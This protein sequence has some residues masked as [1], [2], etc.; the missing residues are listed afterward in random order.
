MTR[1]L[2]AAGLLGLAVTVAGCKTVETSAPAPVAETRLNV[3]GAGFVVP[4][5]IDDVLA[6]LKGA[7]PDAARL[8]G[9]RAEADAVQPAGDEVQWRFLRRR[10]HARAQL[11]RL[12]ESLADLRQSG[13]LARSVDIRAGRRDILRELAVAEAESG[14]FGQA[15]AAIRQALDAME[16]SVGNHETAARVYA[17]MGDVRRARYHGETALALAARPDYSDPAQEWREPTVRFLILQ[18]EGKWAEAESHIRR[19]MDAWSKSRQKDRTPNWLERRQLELSANLLRQGRWQESEL[20]AREVLTRLLASS[21]RANLDTVSAVLALAEAVAAQNRSADALRLIDA[22]NAI[23][24]EVAVPEGARP[25]RVASHLAGRILLARGDAPSALAL[26]EK[27]RQGLPDGDFLANTLFRQSPDALLALAAAGRAAEALPL[28]D[29]LARQRALAYG[30]NGRETV[31]ARGVAAYARFRAGM[32]GE[33]LPA[34]RNFAAAVED[35]ARARGMDPARIRMVIEG[36]VG[37][38]AEAY[39][40][41]GDAGLA[42]EAFA[43][44]E[45]GRDGPVRQAMAAA[46]RRSVAGDGATA[47]MVRR[48][49]DLEQRSETLRSH[50]ARLSA[51]AQTEDVRKLSAALREE[52]ETLEE[53][54]TRLSAT[55]AE[56][57]PAVE[58]SA[59]TVVRDVAAALRPDE[60][61]VAV[62]VAADR[63]YVWALN[64]QGAPHFASVP[65]GRKHVAELVAAIRRSTELR[66]PSLA[67]VPPFDFNAAGALFDAVLRPVAGGWQGARSLVVVPDAA[68]GFL[69][70]SMLP[71]ERTALP[72]ERGPMFAAYRTVPWLARTHAVATVPSAAALVGIRRQ[73]AAQPGRKPFIGFGDPVFAPAAAGGPQVAAVASRGVVHRRNARMTGR[74]SLD[75]GKVM[76]ARLSMLVPLP[77]TADEVRDIAQALGGDAARDVHLG[78]QASERTVKQTA[79]ADRSVVMFATHG[80]VAGDLDGLNQPALALSNPEVV[81]GGGDGLLT[82]EEVLALKLDADWVVLSACNTAAADGGGAEAVSGLGR[83]FFYAG[84]R[85]LLA[86]HWA[87]ET[88]SARLLTNQVFRR[89]AGEGAQP[90]AESLRQAMVAVMDGPGLV[91]NGKTVATYAHPFFWAPFALFGDGGR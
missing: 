28:T 19:S 69:P 14:N 52:L 72:A 66:G 56:R 83:A 23:L 12:D 59:R 90:R 25:R 80:L 9:L 88:D 43:A 42:A 36:H 47:G 79:M 7:Q 64:A 37:A 27:A 89:Q 22:A 54:R 20:I 48:E 13:E 39:A 86:T 57:L 68:L 82:M 84:T 38:L 55:L 11:G 85:A 5:Q 34:F 35:R 33:A 78:S 49:Q 1:K 51:T 6:A 46:A 71:T 30:E 3:G 15:A 21:G 91:E 74:G 75:D 31:E 40:A 62:L 41:G 24:D 10:G 18:T 32:A 44:A 58:G 63:T 70:L 4:R 8:A 65:V 73:Q 16:K 53:E 87:V 29:E 67:D 2:A 50:L 60:A 77:E 17:A 26:F 81:G 61:L 45:L 76:S